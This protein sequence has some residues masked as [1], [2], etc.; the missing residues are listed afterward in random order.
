MTNGERQIEIASAVESY[1]ANKGRMACLD[2]RLRASVEALT[3]L[4]ENPDDPNAQDAIKRLQSDPRADATDL[5]RLGME[6]A[7]LKEFF[8]A[9][10]LDIV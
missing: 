7:R 4:L 10:N 1:S 2:R 5:L 6:Q 9:H 3:L 8:R